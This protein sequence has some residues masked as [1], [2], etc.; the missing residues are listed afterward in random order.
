MTL[1]VGIAIVWAAAAV[2][3]VALC[4]Y[5]LTRPINA[6]DE[7]CARL[8]R[9]LKTQERAAPRRTFALYRGQESRGSGDD[10]VGLHSV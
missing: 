9:I 1:L 3:G 4:W 2:I 10:F 8:D 7:E 5:Q 6:V